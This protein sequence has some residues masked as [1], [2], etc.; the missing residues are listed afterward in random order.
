MEAT[1]Q[2]RTDE[3]VGTSESECSVTAHESSPD[4]VVFTE[5]GNTDGWIATDHT[6]ELTR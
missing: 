4:R 1:D 3:V 2:G 6:V 5:V